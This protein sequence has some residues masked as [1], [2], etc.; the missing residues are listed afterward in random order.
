GRPVPGLPGALARGARRRGIRRRHRGD[1]RASRAV[2]GGAR[3]AGP[4]AGPD[5]D[6]SP[7]ARRQPEGDRAVRPAGDLRR[8][9]GLLGRYL[10][11]YWPAV[12]L[13]VA[14]T[15]AATALAALLPLWIRVR[16]GAAMQMDLFRH[17]LGLSMRFF[18]PQRGGELVSR[19]TTDT[20]AAAAGLET[21]VG[22]VLSAPVL[23]A[24]Y[25]YLLVRTSPRLVM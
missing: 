16:V 12:A 22:T 10:A 2:A 25:G 17:L 15:Y 24:V 11:P 21:I 14:V 23:V 18:T 8:F 3:P 5:R 1:L 6:P 7:A 13:L 20:A 4:G 9:L 19:L